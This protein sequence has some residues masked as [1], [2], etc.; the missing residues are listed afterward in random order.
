MSKV[1]IGLL[2]SINLIAE[3]PDLSG[4]V[5]KRIIFHFFMIRFWY[6][7]LVQDA[8]KAVN[9]LIQQPEVNPK[10]IS[11]IGHSEGGEIVTRVAIENP[12]PKIK[13]IVLIDARI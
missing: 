12:V 4:S 3:F 7:D 5:T 10:K 2:S 1:S 11:I 13:N 6:S 8:Q 9:V